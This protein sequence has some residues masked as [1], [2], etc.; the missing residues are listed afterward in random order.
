M[1]ECMDELTGQTCFNSL[2]YKCLYEVKIKFVLF[3]RTL[4]MITE[5]HL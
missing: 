5:L 1:L 3:E 2:P 4:V